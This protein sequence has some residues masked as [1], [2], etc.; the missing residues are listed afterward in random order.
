VKDKALKKMH[1]KHHIKPIF[2]FT[3]NKALIMPNPKDQNKLHQ[4]GGMTDHQYI[5]FDTMLKEVTGFSV[6]DQNN[7]LAKMVEGIMYDFKGKTNNMSFLVDKINDVVLQC[8][9]SLEEKGLL[10]D[11]S[12]FITLDDD[13]IIVWFGGNKGGTS[14]YEVRIWFNY[15]EQHDKCPYPRDANL[16]PYLCLATYN[17][18]EKGHLEKVWDKMQEIEMTP[19]DS[20]RSMGGPYSSSCAT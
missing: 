6:L 3:R 5:V 1:S 15:Y 11:S 4:A 14:I 20:A 19:D 9:V 7:M 10:L 13:Y 8:I 17:Q 2:V 18:V 16:E 12:I